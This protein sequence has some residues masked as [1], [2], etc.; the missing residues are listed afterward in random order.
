MHDHSE[1]FIIPNIE[2]VRETNTK[3]SK[4]MEDLKTLNKDLPNWLILRSAL[5]NYRLYILFKHISKNW[6][7]LQTVLWSQ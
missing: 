5:S 1:K 6:N 7:H 2:M 4:T 3:I